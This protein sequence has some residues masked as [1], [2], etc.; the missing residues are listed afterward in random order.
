MDTGVEK[1][2]PWRVHTVHKAIEGTINGPLR[3]NHCSQIGDSV[4]RWVVG[5]RRTKSIPR[6]HCYGIS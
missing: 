3:H 6:D 4:R 1:A 2:T 5:S